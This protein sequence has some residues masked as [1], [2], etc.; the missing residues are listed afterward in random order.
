MEWILVV[1]LALGVPFAIAALTR[2][3]GQTT[4]ERA[5]EIGDALSSAGNRTSAVGCGM[6]LAFTVP[7]LGF[8]LAGWLGLAVGLVIAGL[9]AGA[10][11]RSDER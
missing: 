10:A 6:T 8:V 3:P 2:R 1:G 4:S 5:G 7:I 11:F 9:T